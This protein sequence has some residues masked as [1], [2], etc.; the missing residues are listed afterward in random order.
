[1]ALLLLTVVRGDLLSN[2]RA[3]LP[4]D[5]PN[6]FLVNV[7]PDQVDGVRA[8][9]KAVTGTDTT[10]YPMVRGR[11]VAVNGQPFDTTKFDDASA[12]PR[13]AR[14]Q[15]VVGDRPAE[16]QS[17]DGREVVRRE[18]RDPRPGCRW[19]KASPNRCISSSETR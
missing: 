4:P 7:L 10:L 14:V 13:R 2:W 19:K 8:A 18:R 12:A 3:S 9:L 11:I 6:H 17:R 16:D 15:P 5:A 1:M